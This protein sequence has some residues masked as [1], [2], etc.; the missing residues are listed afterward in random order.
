VTFGVIVVREVALEGVGD[1]SGDP[2][3]GIARVAVLALEDVA[4]LEQPF[5]A[6]KAGE[7][8]AATV[9]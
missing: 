6:A 3:A 7:S 9:R 8:G 5:R 1:P 2:T 4:V